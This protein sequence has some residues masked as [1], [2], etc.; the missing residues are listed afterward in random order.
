MTLLM[1]ATGSTMGGDDDAI[2]QLG[3]SAALYT[4]ALEHAR[5]QSFNS[6]RD[7]FEALL[8][9]NPQLEK[10]WISYAQVHLCPL[11]LALRHPAVA[12]SEPLHTVS[13]VIY[14]S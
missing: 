1:D 8:V 12:T 9:L 7:N 2:E 14:V 3:R 13:V 6:A 10:A 11:C 4:V 5:R